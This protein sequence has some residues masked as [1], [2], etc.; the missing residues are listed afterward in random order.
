MRAARTWAALRAWNAPSLVLPALAVLALGGCGFHLQ[1]RTQ[2]PAKL[3]ALRLSADDTQSDFYH[4]LRLSLLNANTQ[5]VDADAPAAAG[6]A[7]RPVQ[8]IIEQDSATTRVLTVSTRNVPTEYELTYAVRY[9]VQMGDQ[10]LIDA[11]KLSLSR[12][13]SYA[14]NQELAKQHE[15]A[16]LREALAKDLA[17]VVMR[18]LASL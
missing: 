9:S 1:G 8:L 10:K 4:A 6:D 16:I 14:E 11:E 15:A 3:A 12:D 17:S 7:P 18:R 13:Y 5:L 2:L